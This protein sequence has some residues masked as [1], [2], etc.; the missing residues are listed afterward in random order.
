MVQT[1]FTKSWTSEFASFHFAKTKQNKTKQKQKTKTKT[2]KE[3]SLRSLR[4]LTFCLKTNN[5]LSQETSLVQLK[6]RTTGNEICLLRETTYWKR[7]ASFKKRDEDGKSIVTISQDFHLKVISIK[8]NLSHKRYTTSW[9]S[10]LLHNL[11]ISI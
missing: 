9:L 11:S 3:K 10:W 6:S 4:Q 7:D 2:N 8:L 5:S 1:V